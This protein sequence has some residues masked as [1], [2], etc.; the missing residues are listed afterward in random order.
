MLGPALAA[1]DSDNDGKTNGEELQ[2]PNG[3]WKTG[4]ANLVSKPGD[5]SSTTGV[6]L[7][8]VQPSQITLK[9][10]YPNPFNPATTISFAIPQNALVHLTIYNSLGQPIRELMNGVSQRGE[11]SVAWNGLNSVGEFM[12]SGVYLARLQSGDFSHTVRMVMRK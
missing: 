2:D 10:N 6:L 4:D 1:L 5:P 7:A 3:E 12:G 8:L 11:H 9:Q